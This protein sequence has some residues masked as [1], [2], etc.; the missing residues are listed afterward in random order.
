MKR[1]VHNLILESVG[2]TLSIGRELEEITKLD[3]ELFNRGSLDM[4]PDGDSELGNEEN[5]SSDSDESSP[6]D[7]E[8]LRVDT[9]RAC[10][11]L[12]EERRQRRNS[13]GDKC[14]FHL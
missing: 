14:A 2:L 13:T 5:V 3:P 7:L 11:S 8:Q 12:S 6:V 9:D 10:A 1:H 4:I